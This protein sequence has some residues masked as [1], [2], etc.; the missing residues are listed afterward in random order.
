M[1]FEISIDRD[2]CIGSGNCAFWAPATFEVDDEGKAVVIDTDGDPEEAIM[3]AAE[4]C[5]TSAISV[6]RSA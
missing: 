1:S 2:V 6:C 3:N 5:P 4:G